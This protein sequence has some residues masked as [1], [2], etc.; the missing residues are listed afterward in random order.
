MPLFDSTSA[1]TKT[2]FQNISIQKE[3]VITVPDDIL[4]NYLSAEE[5]EEFN[6]SGVGIYSVTVYG[7]KLAN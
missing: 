6:K 5:M 3:K 7:E 4:S 2:G 1:K